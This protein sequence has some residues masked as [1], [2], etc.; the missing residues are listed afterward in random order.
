MLFT[1]K[2]QGNISVVAFSIKALDAANAKEFKAEIAPLLDQEDRF[3][4]DL[5][6]LR[7]HRQFW[8]GCN[9]VMSARRFR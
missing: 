6:N 9:F 3:L 1:N 8:I 5:E 7:V 4:F 2:K